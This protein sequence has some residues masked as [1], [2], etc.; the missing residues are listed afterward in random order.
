MYKYQ[1][2]QTC[3]GF[4]ITMKP[5][6]YAT[7]TPTKQEHI[8]LGIRK[9]QGNEEKRTVILQVSSE[10]H[11]EAELCPRETLREHIPCHPEW[12]SPTA[13]LNH[14]PCANNSYRAELK[15]LDG[16]ITQFVRKPHKNTQNQNQM[17]KHNLDNKSSIISTSTPARKKQ[18]RHPL[19]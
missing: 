11:L 19:R 6:V 8:K 3:A 14:N 7:L 17:H 13:I 2:S 4:A 5:N 12:T 16:G 10:E 9:E 15:G 18:T 1:N